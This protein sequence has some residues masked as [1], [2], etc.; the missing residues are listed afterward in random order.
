M[1]VISL[2]FATGSYNQ[3]IA[4]GSAKA[5]MVGSLVHMPWAD[6]LMLELSA[7]ASADYDAQ[8]D[9]QLLYD[10]NLKD[11]PTVYTV[12]G[13]QAVA[14][15]SVPEIRWLPLGVM[16]EQS[17]PVTLSVKGAATLGSTLYLY[18]AATKQYQEIRDGEDLHIVANEHGR[19]FLTQT[20]NTTS[21]DEAE[22][23][24]E[25]VK[26][27]SPV[28]GMIVVSAIE[29]EIERVDVYTLDGKKVMSQNMGAATSVNLQVPSA[30]YI[31]KVHV[32]TL[33]E[34]IT[35]KIA[36]R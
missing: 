30:Y 7:G 33:P 32:S 25:Q 3:S 26:V 5:S 1:E 10:S 11:V 31:V 16:T 19:Y 6:S 21:I 9:A 34:A 35:R 29:P 22:R 14:V 4:I 17:Q 18:D 28:A 23:P 15:N 13:S 27:F 24:D 36:V 8:E 20:R 2:A 12:A